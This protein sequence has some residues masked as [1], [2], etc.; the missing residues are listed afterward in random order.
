MHIK[1]SKHVL[2]I[3]CNCVLIFR[4]NVFEP[5]E[6]LFSKDILLQLAENERNKGK[7]ITA[8]WSFGT[9]QH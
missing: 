6:Y 1:N 3:F 9:S 2:F 8:V 5:Q 4:K 7:S